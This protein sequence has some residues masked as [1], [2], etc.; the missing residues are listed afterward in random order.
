MDNKYKHTMLF[1]TIG[2]LGRAR[3]ALTQTTLAQL[4][5]LLANSG[6]LVYADPA[7]SMDNL[8]IQWSD[9]ETWPALS[10]MIA[11]GGDGSFLGAARFAAMRHVPIVGINRGQLGFLTDVCPQAMS[12]Q[13]PELLA[14]HFTTE[15]RSFIM[16]DD[17]LALNDV[18][19]SGQDA[20]L[21]TF[22]LWIDEQLICTQRADGL[23]IATPT[24]STAYALAAGGPIVHPDLAAFLIVPLCPHRLS[25]RPLLVSSQS[26]LRVVI[27]HNHPPVRISG[28]SHWS[29][30]LQ[31]GESVQLATSPYKLDI[32]HPLQYHYFDTLRAKLGWER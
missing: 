30:T 13:L 23:I 18:V 6:R 19:L 9:P 29:H 4:A 10:L 14:G 15:Q 26:V 1:E 16:V 25:S 2:I 21:V 5:T 28:D 20:R 12:W 8:P 7:L 27:P 22:Q 24:G 17:R 31:P 11:L 3:D 32:L